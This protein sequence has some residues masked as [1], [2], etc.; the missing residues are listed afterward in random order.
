MT[1]RHGWLRRQMGGFREA[2]EGLFRNGL[3]A[4]RPEGP[5]FFYLRE[6][7]HE[8]LLLLPALR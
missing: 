2:E 1:M 8:A 6:K 5:A 3:L 4:H 7:R